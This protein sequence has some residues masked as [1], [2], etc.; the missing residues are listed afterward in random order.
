MLAKSETG[1]TVNGQTEK[2]TLRFTGYPAQ[3][4]T[5]FVD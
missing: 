1:Y 2:K 3:P 5:E 4:K